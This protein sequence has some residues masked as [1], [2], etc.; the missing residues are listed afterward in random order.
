[1]A[2]TRMRGAICARI[3]MLGAAGVFVLLLASGTPTDAIGQTPP[4][5]QAPAQSQPAVKTKSFGKWNIYCRDKKCALAQHTKKAILVFGFNAT[6]GAL[7]MQVRV[8]A[9]A[10]E[11]RPMAIRL[12]KSGA[13]LHLRIDTCAGGLCVASTAPKKTDQVIKLFSKEN[14]GTVAYQLA[15]T[16]MIED[17]TLKNFNRAIAELKKIGPKK[18]KAAAKK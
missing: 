9:E 15:Q 17:F 2:M 14:S 1:M 12:H 7:V 13:L 6:D 10:P 18:R 8:P 11:N 3:S 4:A 5:G 16:L